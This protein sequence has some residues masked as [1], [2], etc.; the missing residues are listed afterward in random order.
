MSNW[1]DIETAPRDGT[2]I[3]LFFPHADLVIRG[4]WEFQGEA[5]WESGI[6]DWQDWCTDN[7]VVLQEDPSYAPTHWMPLIE[8]PK[9]EKHHE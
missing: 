2:W 1:N 3:L 8:P 4:C 6:E 5:D 9:I 7:D